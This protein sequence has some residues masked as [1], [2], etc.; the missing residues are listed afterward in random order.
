MKKVKNISFPL[1]LCVSLFLLL[2]LLTLQ[3]QTSFIPKSD[4]QVEKE[5][6]ELVSKMTL[7][8]KLTMVHGQGF[9]IA[10]IERLGIKAM[11][12]SDASMGLRITPWPKVKGL[13]PSTAF[14]ASI[15][16]AA[17]WNPNQAYN[18]AKAVAEEFRAR[19][20]HIL[21]GPGINIY[22]YPL[23]G[24]NFEYMGEDPFLTSSMVVP[25]VEAVK[26]TR[27]IPV[28]KHFVANNSEN[29]RKNSNSVIDERTLREIYF[30][31]FKAAVT[32]AHTPGIMNA[33]NLLN[34]TFCGEN[35]WLL[36][37]V[38]RDEWGFN[39]MVISDWTSIWNS[40]L[41]ANSGLDIEMPGGQRLKVMGPDSL[42]RLLNDGLVTVEKIDEMVSN[43]IRPSIKLGLYDTDWHDS[44][45]NKLD[46]HAEVALQTAR[47]G[48]TLLKNREKLLPLEPDKVKRIVV[49]GP[50]AAKTPTTGGGSGG[51]RP[52]NP[53]SIWDGM[54]SIYGSSVERLNSFDEQKI[55]DADAVIVCVGLNTDLVIKDFRPKTAKKESVESEQASFNTRKKRGEIEGEGRDRSKFEL[56]DLQ[57]DLITK[58]AAVNPNAVVMITAGGAVDL[59]PW[60]NDVK[61]VLW[62]YYPGQNGSRA[63]AE[64]IAGIV[65][66][67]GK[68][69]FS[70]DWKLSDNAAY[71]DFH[72]EW[73]D[74]KPK[75]SA[76]IRDYQDVVY[77]E[78][79]F[80]GYRHY[81]KE[82]I[83]P[84]F[85][86][87]Y[88]LSYTTFKYS[89]FKVDKNGEIVTVS[90]N[91][92]NSGERAGAEVA[93]V[94]VGD[95]KCTAPRPVKELKGF[96][97]IYLE[98]GEEKQIV[99]E[100][101]RSAF[102]FWHPEKREWTV[103]PGEFKI[104]VGSSS[105]SIL[106]EKTI[107]YK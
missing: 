58:C 11:N 20:I 65:N 71:S 37:E 9:N 83:E 28:V 53:V 91:L 96:S 75:K 10:P 40:K 8:E 25:Y 46:E 52:E 86:F 31:A 3:A 27:V 59:K 5:V 106:L 70:Y 57:N 4:E 61:G 22:R 2:T 15:L 98:P 44:S 7:D 80:L 12:M 26:D 1:R 29:R 47:E 100:L 67:S 97:K 102:S 76:G 24:R 62:M 103:E 17:T 94:Y 87:G 14:P 90:F 107:K 35:R 36:T 88:G 79:I 43:L 56:P 16:L 21:L 73:K 84:A 41:A 54:K 23:C 92:K 63:A 69:P 48:I 72:L 32:K 34:G 19:D 38:L 30:P 95:L 18:Y 33:Y 42:K 66:P 64:I 45:L 93:Q 99:I 50:T 74:P 105:E 82:G 104:S 55:K 51:V 81:D 68:L 89:H 49:I 78:G 60:I 39:G 6:R 101:D 85:P 13:N 77:K